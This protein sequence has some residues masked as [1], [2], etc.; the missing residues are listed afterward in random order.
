MDENNCLS[1]T[2]LFNEFQELHVVRTLKNE[3]KNF[4]KLSKPTGKHD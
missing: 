1:I 2:I 4:H 3:S